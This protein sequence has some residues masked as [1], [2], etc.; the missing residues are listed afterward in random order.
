MLSTGLQRLRRW[1]RLWN[2][3]DVGGLSVTDDGMDMCMSSREKICIDMLVYGNTLCTA[4]SHTPT[5]LSPGSLSTTATARTT[6]SDLLA[7]SQQRGLVL[8]DCTLLDQLAHHPPYSDT[9][10]KRLRKVL[11][12]Y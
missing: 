1:S 2:S 4:R 6:L 5:Y 10:F 11:D 8:L 3:F 7:T 9:T 12:P